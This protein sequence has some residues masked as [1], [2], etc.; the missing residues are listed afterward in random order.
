MTIK[1]MWKGEEIDT[2]EDMKE[3]SYLQGEYN[4]AYGGGGIIKRGRLR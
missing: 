4:L 3:A 1:L 2:A